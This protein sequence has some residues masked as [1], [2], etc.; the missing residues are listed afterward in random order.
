MRLALPWS[1]LLLTSCAAVPPPPV[2]VEPRTAAEDQPLLERYLAD[3]QALFDDLE[4]PGPE[5]PDCNVQ[6]G[7]ADSICGLSG[8]ICDLAEHAADPQ[9]FKTA[10]PEAGDRCHRAADRASACGAAKAR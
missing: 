8:R 7:M 5:A 1:I 9:A 6:Q 4:H 10:C 2:P 3:Q